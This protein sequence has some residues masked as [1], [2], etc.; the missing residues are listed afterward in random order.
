MSMN[1]KSDYIIDF[2]HAPTSEEVLSYHL[3]DDFFSAAEGEIQS[4]DVHLKLRILPL[5]GDLYELKC[6]YTGIV[7]VECD[8]CL[9]TLELDMDVEEGMYVRLGDTL[10]DDDDENLVLDAKEP[11]YDFAHIFYELLAL[12][13]PIQRVHDIEDCDPTMLDY[14]VDAA[15][16]E[17]SNED[18]KPAANPIWDRLRDEIEN[19]S[20]N[21]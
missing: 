17:N 21:N 14:L 2:T 18:E 7:V 8:R 3:G 6:H 4:G 15:P 10:N 19:K 5:P 20:T 12:H 16:E 1:K 13:L 11:K 9:G